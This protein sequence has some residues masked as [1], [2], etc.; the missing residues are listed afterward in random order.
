MTVKRPPGLPPGGRRPVPEFEHRLSVVCGPTRSA[1]RVRA[2]RP[3]SVIANVL[4]KPGELREIPKRRT[5]RRQ[6]R[7]NLPETAHNEPD[8][9]TN[10]TESGCL[11]P[12]FPHR[13]AHLPRHWRVESAPDRR[14]DGLSQFVSVESLP[15]SPVEGLAQRVE[16]DCIARGRRVAHACGAH[17]QPATT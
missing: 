12:Q 9:L 4:G 14:I 10:G 15:D 1:R 11:I 7:L 17:A 3:T 5:C 6:L 13:C 16:V 2:G 8:A